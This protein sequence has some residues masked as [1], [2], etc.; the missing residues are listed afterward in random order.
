MPDWKKLIEGKIA[1]AKKGLKRNEPNQ[2]DRIPAGQTLTTKFPILDLGI[3]PEIDESNWK[4]KVFGLVEKEID[5]DWMSLL[6]LVGGCFSKRYISL[7]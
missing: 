5:L 7:S 2:N 3:R 4:L 1:L 6:K